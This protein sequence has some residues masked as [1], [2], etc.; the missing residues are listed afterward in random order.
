[1][2]K[3]IEELK[4]NLSEKLTYYMVPTVYMEL[5]EMPQTLNG[6]TDLKSLPEPELISE[7]VAPENEVEAF[8]A[9][10]FAEILGLDTVSVEDNFFEIGGTSLLVTKITLAA[11]NRDYE[12]NY[13]DVFK[14]PT[15]RKISEF[16]SQR[17]SS[18]SEDESKYDYSYKDFYTIPILTHQNN[19]YWQSIING[20]T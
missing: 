12:L 16:I 4:E 1:M 19:F 5:D 9:N 7:Y 17:D 15:P 13:G 18:Q 3:D 10:T 14:N 6:K 8:F 11:L 2:D 20:F